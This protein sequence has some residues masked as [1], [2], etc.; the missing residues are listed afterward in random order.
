[1]NSSQNHHRAAE[2]EFDTEF[3]LVQAKA[4]DGVALGRLLEHYRNY[5][6]LLIRLQGGRQLRKRMDAEDLFREIGL[7]I[8]RDI[9]TFR[10][11][12]AREFLMWVRRMIGSI[13]ANQVRHHPGTKYRELERASIEELSRSSRA[14]NRSPAV[15]RQ[16]P[17]RRAVRR[18]QAVIL[19]DALEQLP[20]ADREVI[21]LRHLEGLSFP[22][23]ARR[24]G[25]TED[26]VTNVW[27]RALTRLRRTLEDPG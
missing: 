24:M 3:L 21:I 16:A 25:C 26:R 13:L 23:V 5:L 27:L 10:G 18:E 11:S 8:Q 2:A 20:E 17:G 6:G 22:E 1:M 7:E 14:R 4:G 12:S 9:A 19:A 15:P